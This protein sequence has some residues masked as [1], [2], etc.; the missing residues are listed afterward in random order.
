MEVH[1]PT[2]ADML[3]DAK[4]IPSRE[5]L[6]AHRE[7]IATLRQKNYTWREIA[8]FFRERGMETDHSKL[9][10]FMQ[11]QGKPQM[12]TS[13][14]FFVPNAKDYARVLA[15]LKISEGQKKMLE[16]HY[17]S[18]NRTVNYTN[19]AKQVGAESHVVANSQYGKLGRALG[20]ALAMN[21]AVAEARD[22]P[23]YSSAIGIDNPYKAPKAEF[24]LVMHHELAKAI[25]ELGWFPG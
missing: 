3:R 24:E 2:A 18:H 15:E 17:R 21:F 6:A 13:E 22:E 16:F 20:E 25:Q 11:R 14:D 5:T 23:F 1:M 8:E 4:R 7:T 9:F 10:R 12:N 19:L